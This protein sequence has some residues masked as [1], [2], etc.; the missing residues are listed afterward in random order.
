MNEMLNTSNNEIKITP[1]KKKSNS[2]SNSTSKSVVNFRGD[3][4]L[5]HNFNDFVVIDD[6][7]TD[8]CDESV[9]VEEL[10]SITQESKVK[11]FYQVIN[12]LNE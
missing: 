1:S 3:K 12:L 5:T 6:T 11:L 7:D 4:M 10:E 9:N 8:S 2:N